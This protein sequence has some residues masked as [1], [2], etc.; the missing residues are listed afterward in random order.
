MDTPLRW[1]LQALQITM[2]VTNHRVILIAD[3]IDPLH[4]IVPWVRQL[5]MHCHLPG[6][7]RICLLA[8]CMLCFHR[9]TVFGLGD[10]WV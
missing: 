9:L 5:A 10:W 3:L 4:L 2:M 6:C 1:L 8:L 7:H